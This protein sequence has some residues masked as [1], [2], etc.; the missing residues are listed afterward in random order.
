VPRSLWRP[1]RKGSYQCEDSWSAG[2]HQLHTICRWPVS[3]A[4]F[5]H[6]LEARSV[7][8]QNKTLTCISYIN[9][10]K[11]CWEILALSLDT[12]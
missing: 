4:V 6:K 12:I 8:K 9:N 5:T 7:K 10:Q 11:M 1:H 2:T 3:Y